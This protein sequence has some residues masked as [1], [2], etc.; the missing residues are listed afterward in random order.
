MKISKGGLLNNVDSILCV[1]IYNHGGINGLTHTPT[2]TNPH[3][4]VLCVAQLVFMGASETFQ[5]LYII[6]TDGVI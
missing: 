2:H 5:K 3:I 1:H 6:S 4:F